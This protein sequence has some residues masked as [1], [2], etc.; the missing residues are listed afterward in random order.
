V[1]DERFAAAREAWPKVSI[2][3]ETFA[4]HAA[5][6]EGASHSSDLFL[7]CGVLE[8]D[9]AALAYFE[10]HFM[11]RVPEYILRIRIERDAVQEVQQKLRELLI[12]GGEGKTPKIAEYSG[13]GAL[14]GWLRVT[15]V[16]TALN[17][18]RGASSGPKTKEL[19]DEV[20]LAGDPELAYVKEH[21]QDLFA[22]AFK[23]VLAGLD[24]SGRTIL[25]L[26][27]I[28]GLTMDQLAR[29]YKTPRSTIARRVAEA[30]QQILEATESLLRDEKRLSPSAVAS[31]IRQAKSRLDVTITRLL[32]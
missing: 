13:K 3:K 15:A 16:R 9:P 30:R 29:L 6:H 7:A 20:S 1:E 19:G 10:E 8:R 22:D 32:G 31:V 23:R 25:R 24:E 4:A 5:R 2:S 21:A 17:H 18:I 14:G 26:H 11:A 28:D 27:Y 12:M